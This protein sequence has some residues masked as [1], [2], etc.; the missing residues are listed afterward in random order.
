TAIS[1]GPRVRLLRQRAAS[2]ISA[3]ESGPPDTASTSAGASFRPANSRLASRAEIGEF[4][5]S[6][7]SSSDIE[8]CPAI[9]AGSPG[10]LSAAASLLSGSDCTSALH[11]LL[12]AIDRGFDPGGRA[13]IFTADLAEGGAGG[14]LLLQRG[15]RLAK[16]QQGVGSLAGFIVF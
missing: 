4:S 9:A 1:L 15:Q 3:T 7:L 6:E 2:H 16:P 10:D 11:A 13:R 8:G 12:L 14:L 5:S